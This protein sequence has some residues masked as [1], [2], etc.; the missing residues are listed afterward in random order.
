MRLSDMVGDPRRC[1]G[2]IIITSF[3][4][5]HSAFTVLPLHN[6]SNH[7]IFTKSQLTAPMI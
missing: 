3:L 2:L 5:F 4:V 7:S 6:L 1:K